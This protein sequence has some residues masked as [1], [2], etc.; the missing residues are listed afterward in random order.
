M[1][2][3]SLQKSVVKVARSLVVGMDHHWKHVSFIAERSSIIAMGWNQPYK[4]H[5]MAMKFNY[6][7]NAIHSE[8]HCILNFEKPVKL[9]NKYTFINVRIDDNGSLKMSKPC[10]I[11]KKLLWSFGVKEVWYS[12]SVGTF[13][14]YNLEGYNVH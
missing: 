12:T 11:C 7:Y 5:P 4:T 3:S 8:L 13:D 1:L 10:H 2:N 9:L 14:L 6:R